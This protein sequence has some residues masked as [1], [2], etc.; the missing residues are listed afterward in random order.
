MNR[1]IHG[2]AKANC[3][4]YMDLRS[5]CISRSLSVYQLDCVQPTLWGFDPP[6]VRIPTAVSGWCES[7]LIFRILFLLPLFDSD[8]PDDTR[9]G[10]VGIPHAQHAQHPSH[11][12]SQELRLLKTIEMLIRVDFLY[13]QET[14]RKRV[15]KVSRSAILTM[16]ELVFWYLFVI[17]NNN[18][19]YAIW[20]IDY[21]YY[22][23][24]RL[25]LQVTTI[26]IHMAL[27][28][29]LAMFIKCYS[30]STIQ[31]WFLNVIHHH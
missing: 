10:F 7:F 31:P 2:K 4:W 3:W 24:S 9:H 25:G 5:V 28:G 18:G 26:A 13:T 8:I 29:L 21:G 20:V 15:S 27:Q 17:I 19:Y 11:G 16:T 23:Q 22:S 6:Q 12:P 1:V 30:P 14:V